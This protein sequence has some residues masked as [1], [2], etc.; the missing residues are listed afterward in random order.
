MYFNQ[1]VT[2]DELINL[3]EKYKYKEFQIHHTWKPNYATF[4]QTNID[5]T[6]RFTPE[7]LNTNMKT[8]HVNKGW[9]DI[10]QHI[11]TFPDG[12]ILIGRDFMKKPVG[13][14][15]RNTGAF[16][17]EQLGDFDLGQD[18]ITVNQRNIT[19]RLI[20]Y[21][22][23]KGT[24][25]V[26]HRQF[27]SKTCPGT[28]LHLSGM[29]DASAYYFETRD[30]RKWITGADV[31]DLQKK[32]GVTPIDGSF[33]NDVERA[34]K[35]YQASKN[36]P[37]TGIYD[38]NTRELLEDNND[39][40]ENITPAGRKFLDSIF[41]DIKNT[42]MRIFPSVTLAQACL[43][44]GWGK[45]DKAKFNNFF[46]IKAK[47][48]W[49]GGKELFP[50]WEETNGKKIE[51]NTYFRTYPTQLEGVLDHDEFFVNPSWRENYYDKVL[52]AKT[53]KEQ[54]NA[55]TGTY[56]TDSEYAK[57]L[58]GIIEDYKLYQYDEEAKMEKLPKWAEKE[59]KNLLDK[60]I[61][62]GDGNG[63]LRPNDNITR[64]ECFVL[65]DDLLGYIEYK[66]NKEN[67]Q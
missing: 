27:S 26:F 16:C 59:I 11:T 31:A 52:N 38:K 18:I 17:M 32:L 4:Y 57:K 39:P 62:K 23:S 56:A 55:L 60:K 14:A 34:L 45:S 41:N 54:C 49:K 7:Q 1:R 15:N 53:W 22:I 29:V 10:A 28:S 43:E 46:G 8:Y 19:L 24:K 61:I 12:T 51:I 20:K 64:A 66:T 9:G 63:N 58:I 40:K 5:G 3:L 42:P 47:E 21:F 44:S 2:I 6:R 30:L 48:D 65:V 13:I 36:I 33:G 25:P 50:T 67:K 37:I 35:T